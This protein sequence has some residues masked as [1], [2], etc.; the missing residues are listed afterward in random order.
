[1]SY[2]RHANNRKYE[3]KAGRQSWSD[4]NMGGAIF[5]VLK[6][7]MGYM[8]ASKLFGV[9][10][11]TLEARVRKARSGCKLDEACSKSSACN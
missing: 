10:Q 5:E 7:A 4:E 8:K 3:S 1:M 6:G 9:P 2:C 11:T